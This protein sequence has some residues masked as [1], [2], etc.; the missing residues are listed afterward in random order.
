MRLE[1]LGAWGQGKT[2]LAGRI[3]VAVHPVHSEGHRKGVKLGV[4]PEAAPELK[5]PILKALCEEACPGPLPQ[6]SSPEYAFLR[7]P[8][9]VPSWV[10][11][12]V[13][14]REEQAATE[15]GLSAEPHGMARLID[16]QALA[17]DPIDLRTV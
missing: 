10:P 4:L 17:N 11:T 16:D 13:A 12:K 2:A 3:R 1:K 7:Y 14:A 5:V 6:S 15:T 8:R 9:A